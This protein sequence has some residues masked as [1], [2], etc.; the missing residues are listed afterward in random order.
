MRERLKILGGSIALH[1]TETGCELI[2]EIPI[3]KESERD[4]KNQS[5]NC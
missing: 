3:T 4:E 5:T 1:N 2:A